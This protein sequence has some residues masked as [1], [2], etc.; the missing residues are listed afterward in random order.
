MVSLLEQL[1][2]LSTTAIYF[3]I[4]SLTKYSTTSQL[5]RIIGIP[6]LPVA[7]LF[8]ITQLAPSDW[9]NVF[10][11]KPDCQ[12]RPLLFPSRFLSKCKDDAV[13]LWWWQMESGEHIKSDM[14]PWFLFVN[15]RVGMYDKVKTNSL[16][17]WETKDM[18]MS[19]TYEIYTRRTFPS[20]CDFIIIPSEWLG[21]LQF[22]GSGG[23]NHF[24]H[25]L[26]CLKGAPRSRG[27]WIKN[28]LAVIYSFSMTK[29]L[30]DSQKV[31][32]LKETLDPWM[33]I[34]E[35]MW[36]DESQPSYFSTSVQWILWSVSFYTY[37][38]LKVVTVQ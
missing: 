25:C 1:K 19:M 34:N 5:E 16:K 2:T 11:W 36:M 31:R 12:I 10:R 3:L 35:T 9:C 37:S 6:S 28:R 33:E 13:V 7:A 15:K 29:H 38:V 23:N 4:T 21:P 18:Q 22:K 26:I 30:N 20:D 24:F 8:V 27:D 17:Q 14:L 32:S